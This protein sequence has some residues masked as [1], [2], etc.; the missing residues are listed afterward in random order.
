MPIGT[1]F[2]LTLRGRLTEANQ[3]KFGNSF[4]DLTEAGA[5]RHGGMICALPFAGPQG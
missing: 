2:A 5:K 1:S 3:F 4:R